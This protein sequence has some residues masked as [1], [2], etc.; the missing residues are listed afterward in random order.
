MVTSETALTGR[1]TPYTWLLRVR[2][3]LEVMV[4]EW[5]DVAIHSR[6]PAVE[7]P[8]TGAPWG[9][10][11]DGVQPPRAAWRRHL[12]TQ[13]SVQRHERRSAGPA[14]CGRLGLWSGSQ[15]NLK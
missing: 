4:D 8:G 14:S 11:V 15:R 1:Y 2:G 12:S 6:C 5:H 9:D 7:G 3:L 10:P 13:R